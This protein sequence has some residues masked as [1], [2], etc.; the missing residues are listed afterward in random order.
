[1]LQR[2]IETF[3]AVARLK[4]LK[5][6][7]AKLHLAQSTVSKR[8]QLLEQECGIALFDRWKGGREVTL[9]PAGE[10]FLSVAG[11]LLDLFYEARRTSA[12]RQ[13]LAFSLGTVTSMNA[14]F[15]PRLYARLLDGEPDLAVTI[16]TLHSD[17]MYDA[18]DTRRIDMGLALM[19]RP[20]SSVQVRRCFSEPMFGLRL[21]GDA[22]H[23]GETVRLADLD[24]VQN[25]GFPWTPLYLIWHYEHFPARS[26]RITVDDPHLFHHLLRGAERWTIAPLSV[27]RS[28]AA[29]GAYHMFRL[30]PEP[31]DRVCFMLT[32]KYPRARSEEALA[33]VERHL[34]VVLEEEFG[35][36]LN[37]RG[38]RI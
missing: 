3:L 2:N 20:H 6:A 15:L 11:R 35:P 27:A 37:G 34:R 1:M 4:T 14:V 38:S 25:V 12:E 22:P 9:T 17:E 31:P 5:A 18:I 7:A 36:D 29:T 16:E 32:H 24:P 30:D 33:I 21:A 13:C 23:P 26:S 8:L 10:N 19:E 28:F